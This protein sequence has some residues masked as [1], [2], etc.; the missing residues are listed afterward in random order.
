MASCGERMMALLKAY[1]VDTVFGIPGVHTLELYRGLAAAGI[2]HVGAR[3]EQGAGFMADGYARV[4]GRPGVCV[5][6]TG[7]GVT[8]AATAIAEAYADSSPLLVISS[9]NATGDLGMGRGHLHELKSQEAATA[10]LTGFS[11][12]ALSPAE[13]PE[14]LARA[15]AQFAGGRARPA[16]VAVP[17]DVLAL[18]ADFPIMP[19]PLPAPPVASERTLDDVAA[20]M[21]SARRPVILAGGGSVGCSADVRR[22][23]E[24]LGAAVIQTRASKGVVPADHELSVGATLLRPATRELLKSADLVVALGTELAPTDHW[25]ERLQMGGRLI[26]IDI[27]AQALVRDYAPD[28]AVHGDAGPA[29]AGILGRLGRRPNRPLGFAAGDELAKLRADNIAVLTPKQRKHTKVLDALRAALP[30]D[31]FVAADSTQLAYTGNA[32]FPCPAPRSWF[33]PVGYGTLGFALPAAIGAKL[34]AP[35]RPASVIVGDGGFLFTAQ[36]L[37]TAVDLELPMA[38][39]VWNNDAY[40][41]IRDDM[42]LEGIPEL[43]VRLKN[44]D[45][46]ALAR[47][48]GCH[49]ARPDSLEALRE[50]I[51]AALRAKVPTVIEVRE[52]AAYLS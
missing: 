18:T 9:V 10:P 15:F 24:R 48:F 51:A 45:F 11:A 16:H 3:H 25:Q 38:V 32:Y 50:D 4:S 2:R 14:L 28:V 1:G 47:A 42:V 49:A 6:I 19:R 7:P 8:N 36:E 29:L 12:T 17:I 22:L 46:L 44:P 41:Q 43:G 26:R 30:A 13:V 39:I 20:A 21:E 5:L 52:D 31:G 40:G 34:A 23:A 33:F 35:E 37:A 27:D